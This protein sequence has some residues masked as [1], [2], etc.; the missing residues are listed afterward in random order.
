MLFC[1]Q[2]VYF[3]PQEDPLL[4]R[5]LGQRMANRFKRSLF[6]TTWDLVESTCKMYMHTKLRHNLKCF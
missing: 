4:Q 5:E 1:D 2:K 3:W 6:P